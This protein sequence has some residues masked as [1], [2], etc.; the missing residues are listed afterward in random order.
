MQIQPGLSLP[1]FSAGNGSESKTFAF[2]VGSTAA[3]GE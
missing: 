2:N 3:C 1:C